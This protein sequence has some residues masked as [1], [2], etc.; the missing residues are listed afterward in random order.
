MTKVKS[1]KTCSCQQGKSLNSF[2]DDELFHHF[3]ECVFQEFSEKNFAYEKPSRFV[4]A[5]RTSCA[6]LQSERYEFLQNID[7]PESFSVHKIIWKHF[8]EWESE[9][10]R[11]IKCL[12]EKY[13]AHLS[14]NTEEKFCKALWDVLL[15]SNSL[16]IK[17]REPQW[18]G[19]FY[20]FCMEMLLR[21]PIF[22]DLEIT[23]VAEFNKRFKDYFEKGIVKKECFIKGVRFPFEVKDEVLQNCHLFDSIEEYI[24]YTEN[25]IK[26]YAYDLSTSPQDLYGILLL[27]QKPM[28]YYRY[29]LS[30]Q[31]YHAKNLRYQK[32]KFEQASNKDWRENFFGD[33]CCP[34]F[35]HNGILIRPIEI[36]SCLDG[37]AE[38]AKEQLFVMFDGDSFKEKFNGF[39]SLIADMFSIDF[40]KKGGR[41]FDEKKISYKPFISPFIKLKDKWLCA[42][43]V[44]RYNDWMYNL[45]QKSFE[46]LGKNENANRRTQN[47]RERENKIA[48]LFRKANCHWRVDVNSHGNERESGDWDIKVEDEHHILLIQLKSPSLR[49]RLDEIY[50]EYINSDLKAAKQLNDLT[51]ETVKTVSRWIVST[52]YEKCLEEIDGCLK[53]NYFDL[54]WALRSKSN[55][56][57]AEFMG[58][59]ANDGEL[60]KELEKFPELILPIKSPN[61]IQNYLPVTDEGKQGLKEVNRVK[62]LY[63]KGNFDDALELLEKLLVQ[64]PDDFVLLHL[65][66][67]IYGHFRNYKRVS[68]CYEKALNLMPNDAW[69]LRNYA[70]DCQNAN[71]SSKYEELEKT[72]KELSWFIDFNS[73]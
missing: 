38:S 32:Y 52:S 63:D 17:G 41:G 13:L 14:G 18:V 60:R 29:F 20:A 31:R 43:F 55:V 8:Y 62:E 39:S 73:K 36:A 44:F 48:D 53:V 11:E 21:N 37:I 51:I 35:M 59:I 56:E 16:L 68:E 58:H 1:K 25:T 10:S 6:F 5:I 12:F 49:I 7:L 28:D 23:D 40:R 71:N 24:D 22:N 42:S 70:C 19:G 4:K 64:R 47:N 65:A 45:A 30:T 66:T 61:E 3:N 9:K 33:L 15:W 54:L 57:L 27:K 26:L 34:E 67:D 2:T 72:I 50:R 46:Y 69:T